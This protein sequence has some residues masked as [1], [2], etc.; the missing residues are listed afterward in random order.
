M[1]NTVNTYRPDVAFEYEAAGREHVQTVFARFVEAPTKYVRLGTITRWASGAETYQFDYDARDL[2]VRHVGMFTSQRGAS[3]ALLRVHEESAEKAA[4]A[5]VEVEL[6]VRLK[7]SKA[8]WELAY[9]DQGDAAGLA[10]D[11]RSYVATLLWQSS[12]ARPG[13]EGGITDVDVD[14]R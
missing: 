14:H 9:G 11:V 3:L 10:E 7:V 6:T 12:Q 4:E 8:A 2:A 5:P 1:T 13:G